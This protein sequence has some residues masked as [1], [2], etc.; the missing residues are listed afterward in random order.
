M[1]KVEHSYG[2]WPSPI[3]PEA[4]AA[5]PGAPQWP[6]VVGP[7][8]WW[9]APD[10]ATATV[11]LTR[12]GA[13]G[14]TRPVL[15]PEWPVGNKAIGYGGRPYLATPDV[16]VF[17]CSRD[18]RLYAIGG[19]DGPLS[20][21]DLP[22]GEPKALTPADAE[23]TVTNYSDPILDPTGT[24]VWVIREATRLDAAGALTDPAPRTTR[25]IVAV[26]LSGAAA[27]TPARCASSPG[28]TSSCPRSG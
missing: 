15:G 9:C 11:G 27:R 16:V 20:A 17:S 12:R 13:D 1:T 25:D 5:V 18:Q 14:Q 10:P 28:R 22:G 8:T 2:A 21:A 6:T 4:A 24:E 23:G 19:G 26:P 3:T 7:E